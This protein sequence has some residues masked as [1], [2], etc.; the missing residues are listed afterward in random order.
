MPHRRVDPFC[1]DRRHRGV[2]SLSPDSSATFETRCFRDGSTMSTPSMMSTR[3]CRNIWLPFS[4]TP[5][6]TSLARRTSNLR[7][8]PNAVMKRSRFLY[9]STSSSDGGFQ[10]YGGQW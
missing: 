2:K 1:F 8:C 5:L 6:N 3:F 7:M 4:S 9:R 10:L